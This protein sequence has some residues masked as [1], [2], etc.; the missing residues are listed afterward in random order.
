MRR[1]FLFCA[2]ASIHV[3]AKLIAFPDSCRPRQAAPGPKGDPCRASRIVS[4]D[5][6]LS[7]S[8]SVSR[9]PAAKFGLRP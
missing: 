5:R 3:P 1:V 9:F 4:A 8:V 6:P 7:G 2:N